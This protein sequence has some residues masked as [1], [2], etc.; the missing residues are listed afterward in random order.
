MVRGGY[1]GIRGTREQGS[2]EDYI[3]R[4]IDSLLLNKYYLGDKSRIVRW[5]GGCDSYGGQERW[6]DL[7]ESEHFKTLATWEDNIKM[8][9]QEV[10]WGGMDWIALAS[11]GC[12]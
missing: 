9:L 5:A 7:M 10:G 2:G 3:T 8:D 6:G 4:N 12:L 11:G 1:L